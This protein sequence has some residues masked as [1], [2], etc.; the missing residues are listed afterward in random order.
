M[1]VSTTIEPVERD[2]NVSDSPGFDF[3]LPYFMIGLDCDMPIVE[4][5]YYNLPAHRLF[6]CIQR[7]L[8]NDRIRLLMDRTFQTGD[9]IVLHARPQYFYV[10]EKRTEWLDESFGLEFKNRTLLF[11]RYFHRYNG[12]NNGA[13]VEY[14]NDVDS[15]LS[16]M[17][18]CLTLRGVLNQF[19][20]EL[21]RKTGISVIGD[22][23]N[24]SYRPFVLVEAMQQMFEMSIYRLGQVLDLRVLFTSIEEESVDY[25]FTTEQITADSKKSWVVKI[26][27]RSSRP[28]FSDSCISLQAWFDQLPD[29]FAAIQHKRD[30]SPKQSRRKIST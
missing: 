23:F 5:F 29:F 13:L 6:G 8:F 28:F 16:E 3:F 17:E 2:V 22:T 30:D 24:V 21:E 1:N 26:T 25:R 27:Q 14:C 15:W 12:F 18:T 19:C 4:A 9:V 7:S 10:Q 20:K 11:H